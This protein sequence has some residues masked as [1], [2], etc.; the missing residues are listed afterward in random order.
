[1]EQK[2]EKNE[3]YETLLT[4]PARSGCSH[5]PDKP[6]VARMDMYLAVGFGAATVTKNGE[7]V[8]DENRWDGEKEDFPTL[9]RYEL[10]AQN[11]P[12]ADWRC[13]FFAPLYEAEY[14]RQ[15]KERWV[16]IRKGLGFA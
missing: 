8:Y 11:E 4:E 15:G 12:D 9:G 2:T 16:L 3:H 7:C 5:C 10:L 13:S 6:V 14:Q 1:M